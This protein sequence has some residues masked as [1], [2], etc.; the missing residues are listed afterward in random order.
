MLP[1]DFAIIE[2]GKLLGLIEYDGLQHFRGWGSDKEDLENI[3]RRDSI[4]DNY[5][6][7][8]DIQLVRIT[9]KEYSNLEI[10]VKEAIDWIQQQNTQIESSLETS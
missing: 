8:N 9:Y 7:N 5:C 10:K 6:K 3:K 2:K 1:F 4:K